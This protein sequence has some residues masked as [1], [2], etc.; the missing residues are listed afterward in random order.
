VYNMNITS[1]QSQILEKKYLNK[2]TVCLKLQKPENYS[3]LPGQFL[4]IFFIDI[5]RSYSIFSKPSDETIDLCIKCLEGGKASEI[6]KNITVEEKITISDPMGHFIIN[7]DDIERTYVATGSGI[8][9]IVSMLR[10]SL[11]DYR[12]KSKIYLLFGIRYEEDIFYIK[13][14]EKLS[15]TYKN[16][17]FDFTLSR[18]SENWK[19]NSGRVSAHLP[20]KITDKKNNQFY[21]CGSPDMVKDIRK[22]LIDSDID[23]KNIKFEIF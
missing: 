9:P 22:L 1:Y 10:T 11:E 5:K 14:L 6:I 8:A 15:N 13:E 21:L 18:P 20:S 23:M 4:Q 16:F 7:E 19:G 2:D 12:H 17:S 3:F